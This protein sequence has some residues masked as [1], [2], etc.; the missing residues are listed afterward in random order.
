V[1]A[2]AVDVARAAAV[3]DAGEAVGDHLG[4][5]ADGDR[6]VTHSFASLSPAYRG[7]RWAVTVA[8]ASRSKQVTVDE[9]VLLPGAE[10]VLAPEWVPWSERL[11]P[12]DLGIGDLLPTS[13]DDSRLVPGYADGFPTSLGDDLAELAETDAAVQWQLGLGRARILSREGRDDTALRWYAGA[14]GPRAPIAEAAPAQCSTCGFMV[15]LSGA[16]RGMFG[17]CANEYAPDDGRVVAYDHGCGAHSEAA[18]VPSPVPVT[19]PVV[20]EVGYDLVT[21]RRVGHAPGSV[22]DGAPSE[23]LGH[24]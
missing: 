21:V 3:E 24:S 23:D 11:R 2:A 6:V 18:V 13:Q 15:A 4:V 10:S 12:G 8:R 17:A 16:L 7:W 19:A 14:P 5:E 9:V 1:C 20:D 22:E